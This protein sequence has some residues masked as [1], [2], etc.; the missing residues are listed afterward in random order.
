[1]TQAHRIALGLAGALLAL[2]LAFWLL[3][4]GEQGGGSGSDAPDSGLEALRG[5]LATLQ[6]A[7]AEERRAR[8]ILASE[9]EQ[10]R[11]ALL[12]FDQE[13]QLAGRDGEGFD[14]LESVEAADGSD[15]DQESGSGAQAGD[16][17][18]DESAPGGR[19]ADPVFQL[20]QL[21][22]AGIHELEAERVRAVWHDI[23]LQKLEV[24]DQALREGWFNSKR[25]KRRLADIKREAVDELG[26]CGY[27]SLLYGTGKD[28]RVVV[29]Q[30]LNGS[31]ADLAGIQ[32][33]DTVLRYNDN[34]VWAA[35]DLSAA[36]SRGERGETVFV[37]IERQGERLRVRVERGPFGLYMRQERVTPDGC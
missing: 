20:D 28:N 26:E 22:A 34:R 35:S 31:A 2:V 33:G 6:Q 18:S 24:R 12:E 36:T 9:V 5:E 25:F 14:D 11:D 23:Q 15:P 4:S 3:P 7:L 27:D 13:M 32:A 1:M 10:L 16:S 37:D 21:L 30:V 8:N 19:P 29:R 17:A